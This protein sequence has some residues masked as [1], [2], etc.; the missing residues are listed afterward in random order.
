MLLFGNV[1]H[2]MQGVLSHPILCSCNRHVI[3]KKGL[4]SQE[5]SCAFFM[6]EQLYGVAANI[7]LIS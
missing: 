5:F 7:Q 3:L 2:Y 6:E 1:G 4:H